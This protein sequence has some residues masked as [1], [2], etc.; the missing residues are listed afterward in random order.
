MKNI[1]TITILSLLF[2][3]KAF[4]Q[5]EKNE[6]GIY[7]NENNETYTGIYYEYYDNGN[8]RVEMNLKN[9][10]KDGYTNI[11]FLS[12]IKKEQR[13]YKEGEMHGTWI[14][15]NELEDKLAEA[16]YNFGKKHGKWYIWDENGILRYEM[17]YKKG[18][19]FGVWKIY[20][21][22]GTLLNKMIYSNQ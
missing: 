10:I 6:N 15:W 3:S 11:Y 20:D 7:L 5:I 2:F 22:E 14:T 1:I 19:K 17:E 16:N 9:G 8:I 21:E 12:G 18:E 4:A 13:S